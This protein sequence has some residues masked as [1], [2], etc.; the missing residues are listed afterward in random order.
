ME[1]PTTTTVSAKMTT[2]PSWSAASFGLRLSN[3]IEEAE[4][5]RLLRANDDADALEDRRKKRMRL[6]WAEKNDVFIFDTDSSAS[7][8]KELECVPS[9]ASMEDEPDLIAHETLDPPSSPSQEYLDQITLEHTARNQCSIE[10][11]L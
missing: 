5:R 1:L 7:D 3:E 8:E 9:G 4:K 11:P 2:A 6:R 10:T